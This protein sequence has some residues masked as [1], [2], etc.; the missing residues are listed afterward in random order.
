M[1]LK[2]FRAFTLNVR[3]YRLDLS[4]CPDSSA[5]P[6]LR[7]SV[8]ARRALHPV[9]PSMPPPPLVS[10]P[11]PMVLLSRRFRRE[12][13]RAQSRNTEGSPFALIAV[14]D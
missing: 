1:L 11:N 6:M 5:R 9:H 2:M 13:T 8:R 10:G 4:R 12:A 14:S 7:Q 3:L